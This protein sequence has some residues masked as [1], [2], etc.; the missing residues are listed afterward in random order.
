MSKINVLDASVYNLISAGEVVENPCSV[1]KELIENSIDA[2]ADVIEISVEDGGIKS[3]TVTDNGCGIEK[4]E[5]E[6]TILPHATSKIE[7]AKDL[8][9]IGTLGFRGEALASIATVSEMTIK[10]KFVSSE[11]AYM[12]T[13]CGGKAGKT[14]LTNL[15]KGTSITVNNLFFNTPVRYKFLK[16]PKNELSLITAQIRNFIFANHDIAFKYYVDN[17]L[18]LQ[19]LGQGLNDALYSVFDAETANNL[20]PIKFEKHKYKIEGYIGAPASNAILNNKSKQ[21]LIVNGR[22]INDTVISSVIQN[23]YGDFLMKRTFP[24]YILEIIMPF[25]LVDVNVHPNKREVRFADRRSVNGIFYNAVKERLNENYQIKQS[26]IHS[27]LFNLDIKEHSENGLTRADNKGLTEQTISLPAIVLDDED[28]NIDLNKKLYSNK[29]FILNNKSNADYIDKNSEW[30]KQPLQMPKATY[31]NVDD[32][33]ARFSDADDG[34]KKF[35]QTN[36]SNTNYRI[37]G[38]LFETYILLECNGNLLIIDQHAT[39]ER[40]IYDR[41]I[42]ESD[43][44]VDMQQLLFPYSVA[45]DD[46]ETEEILKQIDSLN[47]LGFQMEIKNNRALLN[48]IPYTLIDL[49]ISAFVNDIKNEIKDINSLTDFSQVRKRLATMACKKAIKGGDNLST[50]QLDYVV[51]YFFENNVALQCPHGRP[52]VKIISKSDVEKMFGRIV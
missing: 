5:L 1:V 52:T 46:E 29:S 38:Q 10:S 14:D 47:R 32:R 37:I 45:L 22:I 16:S 35:V 13:V 25:D 24:I 17:K 41:L 15:S 3:I 42:A 50:E 51:N 6:K 8:L 18:T 21:I 48:A 49:D 28:K 9:T 39:H 19:T 12:L 23:A 30:G 34:K 31:T 7:D 2:G 44:G 36:G 20:L 43:N 11:F 33:L 27:N 40:I 4:E 26:D